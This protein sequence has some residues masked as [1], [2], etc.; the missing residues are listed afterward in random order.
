MF[1]K[2]N[3]IHWDHIGG[4]KYFENITKDKR[5]LNRE[6]LSPV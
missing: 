5:E 4:H 1:R 2:L 6:Y 3:F